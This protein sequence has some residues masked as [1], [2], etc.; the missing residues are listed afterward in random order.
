MIKKR[1][2]VLEKIDRND[3]ISF[4]FSNLKNISYGKAKNDSDFFIHY[5]QQL[6][7]LSLLTWDDIRSTQKHGLGAETIEVKFLKE[8]AKNVLSPG[9]S[10]LLVLRATGDNHVFLGFRDANTFQVIFIE[11]KFGDIYSHG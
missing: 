9:I 11:Y 8:K 5:L 10:K 1:K 6:Q 7:K 2:P 4:G 3:N